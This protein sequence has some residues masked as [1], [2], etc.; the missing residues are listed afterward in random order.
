[1]QKLTGI[2]KLYYDDTNFIELRTINVEITDNIDE[3]TS[4]AK[5][6]IP[7][8]NTYSDRTGIYINGRLIKLA[9]RI[10]IETGYDD[11]TQEL[12]R[13][14]VASFENNGDNLRIHAE[15]EFYAF[16]SSKFAIRIMKSW[17]ESDKLTLKKLVEY[18]LKNG[19]NSS[20][21]PT[22]KVHTMDMTIGGLDLGID[23]KL[24]PGEVFKLLQD[25]LGIHTYFRNNEFHVGHK[26][27]TNV[28]KDWTKS[29]KYAKPFK[30][31]YNYILETNLDYA[32]IDANNYRV[33]ASSIS[34][35]DH[36]KIEYA[37]PEGIADPANVIN[38]N[39]NGLDM[40]SLKTI[41]RERYDKLNKGG[42]N[43]S[44]T[45]FG[46]PRVRPG[47]QVL[48]DI[49]TSYVRHE[50]HPLTQTYYVDEVKTTFGSDGYKQELKLGVWFDYDK[51]DKEITAKPTSKK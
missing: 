51:K 27:W 34:M 22:Y 32:V 12:F 10:I 42:L 49:N 21:K 15:D 6:E 8:N 1:M 38:L 33:K 36:K 31:G 9:N 39:L 14:Y 44:I 13:G 16:K 4:L 7:K 24:L 47:D 48:I 26:Y 41:V 20:Y 29:F 3:L 30:S 19:F 35:I 46:N 2:L 50:K 17:K 11:K 25:K 37:Y 28:E 18:I 23:G 43:G 40:E 5:V 45:V